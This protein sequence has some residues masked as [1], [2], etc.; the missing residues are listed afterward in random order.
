M[1][2]RGFLASLLVTPML[3]GLPIGAFPVA[4][5]EAPSVIDEALQQ[6]ETNKQAIADKESAI[7]KLQ[8]KIQEL[9]GQRDVTTTQAEIIMSQITALS[10][11]LEK[12]ELELERTRLHMTTVGKQQ[13]QTALTIDNLQKTIDGKREE[14]RSLMRSLYEREQDSVVKIFLTSLSLSDVLADRMVY[15]ELQNRAITVIADMHAR[16]TELV[17]RQEDLKQQQQDL[18]QLAQLLHIQQ[19]KLVSQK[20][21]QKKF[22]QAKKAEQVKYDNLLADAKAAQEEIQQQV[23]TLKNAG[24]SLSLSNASDMARLAGKLTAIRPALLLGV[25]KVESNVGNNI[26]G[27]KFP[28]DMLP[29]SREA[30]LRITKKLGLDPST[31]PISARPRSYSGWGGAM[32]PA[33]VM[34]QTWETIES[35]IGDLLKKAQPSPYDLQDAFVA[36]AIF[37]ADRGATSPD[38]EYEAVNRYLAGPNWQ[39]FTWY[40]DRV[41]AVAKEYAKQGL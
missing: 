23:F 34:P 10:R 2:Y 39:R 4:A 38:R 19:E 22:L 36:T 24:V 16:E 26:G 25:L 3:A 21:E 37:L 33:Q 12:E 15:N 11:Q 31:A 18:S 13:K 5:Q 6:L 28:D 40:G 27:G 20:L 41:L 17:Q 35:R 32:G 30:F 14:L 9:R 29:S 8:K 1:S 7:A